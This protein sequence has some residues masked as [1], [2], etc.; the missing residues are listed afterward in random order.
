MGYSNIGKVKYQMDLDRKGEE[1]QIGRNAYSTGLNIQWNSKNT[2]VLA[3]GLGYNHVMK[4][5]I[6]FNLG[7]SMPL[8]FPDDENIN[9]DS[10]VD[11]LP[12]DIELTEQ[13]IQEETFYGPVV[14]YLNVG[15]NMKKFWSGSKN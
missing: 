15:Y 6:S 1:L 3:F 12:E 5:G 4:N 8:S 14:I 2:Q 11:I 9:I 7:I 13:Q 10:E